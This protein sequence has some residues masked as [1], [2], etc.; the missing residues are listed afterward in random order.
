MSRA[1]G[2]KL[3]GCNDFC[4]F[5]SSNNSSAMSGVNDDVAHVSS[6][7]FSPIN[8]FEPHLHLCNGLSTKGSTGNCFSS[9]TAVSLHFL[10]YQT[11]IGIPKCLCLDMFQS[12]FSPLIQFS[13]LA[14]MCSG[15]HFIFLPYFMK[16]SFKSRYLMNHW[17]TATYSISVSHLSWVLTTCFIFSSLTIAP[18][19]C[20]SS[21]TFFLASSLLIP[22]YRPDSSLFFPSSP[23]T[24]TGLIPGCL[25]SHSMQSRLT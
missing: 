7:S 4:S 11:G 1:C 14:R 18:S 24:T 22:L 20:R 3:I 23:I 8:S 12:H 25:C 13:Y 15:Y 21:I 16:S 17:S 9:A 10:Q 6:T 19:F 2:R 5:L